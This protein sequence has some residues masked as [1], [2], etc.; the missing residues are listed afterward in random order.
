MKNIIT[1][2]NI[3]GKNIYITLLNN[4]RIKLKYTDKNKNL[5]LNNLKKSKN[6]L[7][8]YNLQLEEKIIIN[9]FFTLIDIIKT[10]FCCL[11]LNSLFFKL[12]IIIFSISLTLLTTIYS[13][14]YKIKSDKIKIILK[15]IENSYLPTEEEFLKKIKIIDIN[16]YLNNNSNNKLNDIDID[17]L[18]NNK[19][20]KF[21][22]D[23][24]RT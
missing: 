5:I 4:N 11:T 17:N 14:E 18:E 13:M 7:F 15:N 6:E 2:I 8:S 9:S 21:K 23:L 22:K 3:E 1:D 24:K 16:T 20:L 19:I 10:V 12:A